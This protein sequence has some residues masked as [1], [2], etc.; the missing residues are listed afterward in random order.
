MVLCRNLYLDFNKEIVLVSSD[1][2][3][4]MLLTTGRSFLV[5]RVEKRYSWQ[6][7]PVPC[8]VTTDIRHEYVI[9]L[10][11]WRINT[12]R[13]LHFCPCLSHGK[14]KKVVKKK[15]EKIFLFFCFATAGTLKHWSPFDHASNYPAL[16]IPLTIRVWLEG[17]NPVRNEFS[18]SMASPLQVLKGSPP[19][20]HKPQRH[21]F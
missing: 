4:N 13:R 5:T 20:P 16:S 17:V 12:R 11:C 9:V 7:S 8:L 3:E 6:R 21:S 1:V 19:V 2:N 15:K 14:S 18:E 10:M